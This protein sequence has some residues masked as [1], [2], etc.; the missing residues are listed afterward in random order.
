MNSDAPPGLP[1]HLFVFFLDRPKYGKDHG[2][3]D[4]AVEE[5]EDANHEED[6][7]EQSSITESWTMMERYENIENVVRGDLR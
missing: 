7:G 4:E 6:L 2:E 3:E 1:P 5:A